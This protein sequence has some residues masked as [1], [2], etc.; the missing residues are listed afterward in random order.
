M[1]HLIQ[2]GPKALNIFIAIYANFSYTFIFVLLL[3]KQAKF[4]ITQNEQKMY[5]SKRIQKGVN[6][7][8]DIIYMHNMYNDRVPTPSVRVLGQYDIGRPEKEHR[9]KKEKKNTKSA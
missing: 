8:N 4:I 6:R 5:I 2:L 1:N 9:S 7:R 3:P